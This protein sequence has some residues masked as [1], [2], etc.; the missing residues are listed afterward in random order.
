[1]HSALGI[2]VQAPART[3]FE[4]ARDVERWAE[5][6]PHY[7]QVTVRSRRDDQVLASMVAVR[8]FGPLPVPVTWRAV[9]WSEP[10]DPDD[11]R[12]RFRHVRGVTRGMDVT[13]HIH[14]DG[15][16][17]CTVTIDHVF[18]RP[19]PIVGPDLVP[20]LVDRWFTRAIAGRT[21]RRFRAL[22]EARALEET[23]TARSPSAPSLAPPT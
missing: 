22:A 6:L 4:I 2:V 16:D 15:P 10:A 11:L 12:L 7:R 14:P 23:R 8:R 20:R 13:W 1:V 17:R 19:L 9:C 5:L 3:V 18:E 21:L